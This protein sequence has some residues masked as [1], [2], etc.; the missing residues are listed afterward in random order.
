MK[1]KKKNNRQQWIGMGI[2]LLVGAVCGLFMSH[3]ILTEDH[4][5]L[6]SMLLDLLGLIL[7]MLAT[8]YFHTITHELGH[9][10]FGLL[11]GYR[12]SSFRVGNLAWVKTEGKIRFKRYTVAGTGGQC[13][14][15]PPEPVDGKIPV[16]WYNMGGCIVNLITTAVF[17]IG[18]LLLSKTNPLSALFLMGTMTGLATALANGIP[19]SLNAMDNDGRNALFL[20]KDP[21]SMEAFRLQLLIS[22]AQLQDVR[23]KDM[24]EAWFPLPPIETMDTAM[25]A[26]QGVFYCNRLMDQHRFEEASALIDQLL[27]AEVPMA[28][29]HREILR[30]ERTYCELIGENRWSVIEGLRTKEHL[31][32]LSAMS[33]SL[34]VL[35]VEYAYAL[36]GEGDEAAAQKKLTRFEKVVP[37]HPFP[38]DIAAERELIDIAK[39]HKEAI[40]NT[41]E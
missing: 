28:G 22:D 12:Y 15:V 23:L 17:Y 13:L 26:A 29:I 25:R 34:F 7:M 37:R 9:L 35:R 39:S 3:L 41:A 1:K 4:P 16:V 31:R 2:Y 36:L 38:A 33:S 11:T 30:C 14:M 40:E 8:L 27:S 18:Y 21:D 6:D 24:P 32:F 19:L 10:I 5:S 20:R